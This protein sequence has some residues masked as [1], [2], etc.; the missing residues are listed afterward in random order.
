MDVVNRPLPKDFISTKKKGAPILWIARNCRAVNGREAYIAKLREYVNIDS[1][2]GC[3][4]NKD[5]P[6]DKSRME[7]LAEYKFYLAAENSNCDNY[8]TEKLS[9]TISM[10]AVPIV[11]GPPSYE[12]YVPSDRSIIHMDAYPDPRDLAD[13]INYLDRNDTAYL[14]YLSFRRDA[15]NIPAKERLDPA[16]ISNWSDTIEY[17]KTS[18]YCS[19]CRGMIPWWKAKQDGESYHE[20]NK[21]VFRVDDSCTDAGKW[22]YITQGPPYIPSWI[23]RARDEFTRPDFYALISNNGSTLANT[24]TIEEVVND[25]GDAVMIANGSFIL[26]YIVFILV[27]LRISKKSQTKNNN[28][29]DPLL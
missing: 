18:S 24:T 13:Y 9:D 11:D 29:V 2:G 23:P 7:L 6:V 19:I 27:L 8:V 12:G 10:S 15:I 4:N 1:Y 14:E 25:K 28:V 5:F 20:P 17:T 3:L 26:L 22:N 16:F 21:D